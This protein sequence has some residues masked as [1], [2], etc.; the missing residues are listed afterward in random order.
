M[1]VRSLTRSGIKGGRSLAAAGIKAGRNLARTTANSLGKYISML[2]GISADDHVLI[3]SITV[4]AGGTPS[5]TFA[6]I[7]QGY[8]SLELRVSAQS[9]GT[10]NALFLRMNGDSGTNYSRHRLFGN[11]TGV[12]SDSSV[13][14]TSI[15]PIAQIASSAYTS[16][17]AA[18]VIEILDYASSSKFKTARALSGWD[19]NGSGWIQ[20]ASGAWQSLSPVTSLVLQLASANIAQ[21]SRFDLYGVK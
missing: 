1:A 8:R 10:D 19:G 13:S 5:V 4:G 21:G 9:A 20:L 17:V 6:S 15:T 18:A 3:Q 7:P 11:G 12:G 2:A 16:V 14:D